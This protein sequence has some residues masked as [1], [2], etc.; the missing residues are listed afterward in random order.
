MAVGGFSTSPVSAEAAQLSENLQAQGPGSLEER[1]ERRAQSALWRE[2]RCGDA[3]ALVSVSRCS[4]RKRRVPAAFGE[5]LLGPH[6]VPVV[7]SAVTVIPFR[8]GTHGTLE[9]LRS[10]LLPHYPQSRLCRLNFQARP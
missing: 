6:L 5:S 8:H 7:I 3:F 2:T 9:A 10:L 1:R 4:T